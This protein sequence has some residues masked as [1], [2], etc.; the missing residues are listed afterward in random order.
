MLGHSVLSGFLFAPA[1]SQDSPLSLLQLNTHSPPPLNIYLCA[2]KRQSTSLSFC[3]SLLSELRLVCSQ[4]ALRPLFCDLPARKYLVPTT[5]VSF[6]FSFSL[7]KFTNLNMCM[8]LR[9][10]KVVSYFFVFPVGPT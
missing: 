4:P 8:Q 9:K 6:N 10:N 7:L 1:F 3:N 5:L 2:F